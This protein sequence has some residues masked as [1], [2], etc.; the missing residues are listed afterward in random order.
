[1][2]ALPCG[3]VTPGG[4]GMSPA[5]AGTESAIINRTDRNSFMAKIPLTELSG[6]SI[7][8]LVANAWQQS[9]GMDFIGARDTL[10]AA[11]Y[12]PPKTDE[13]DPELLLLQGTL[14]I[15]FS[16][17]E[18]A[19]DVLSKS[20]RF[21]AGNPRA[22]RAR[23][24]LA[25]AY[26]MG[27]EKQEARALLDEITTTEYQCCYLMALA[28]V[29]STPERS[30]RLYE[31]AEPLLATEPVAVQ[32][33]FH[34]SRGMVLRKLANEKDRLRKK[35]PSIIAEL[36]RRSELEYIAT[37]SLAEDVNAH[38][39]V[40]AA[41]NNLAGLYSDTKQT[42][43]A[44]NL[45]D[46]VV[47]HFKRSRRSDCL[48]KSLDQK[49]GILLGQKQLSE[50]IKVARLA[51][52]EL[53]QTDRHGWL[54]EALITLGTA[55]ARKGDTE[56]CAQ[57]ERAT[58]ICDHSGDKE[59]SDRAR[60]T[61]IRELPVSCEQAFVLFS[62]IEDRIQAIDA[63]MY[64][65]EAESIRISLEAASGSKLKAAKGL[66]ITRQA[67]EKKIENNFP[68]FSKPKRKRRRVLFSP[69]N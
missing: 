48:G 12:W 53:E 57:L 41:S 63:L 34:G 59:Q 67:L 68:Q 55:L 23:V 31:Q 51:V 9:D 17:I 2:V 40:I 3:D 8:T 26:L 44:L 38:E 52:G 11:G 32:A 69:R 15:H 7:A 35:D 36:R 28:Y 6:Q 61:I 50:A 49:A 20:V 25:W 45:V 24:M 14:L 56:A 16:E 64:R 65:L 43:E 10:G 21:F 13:S 54:A 42:E 27:G 33:K 60:V 5:N 58:A 47:S 22:A 18:K 4:N 66:G 37:L 29:Q 30:L 46:R 19:K 1:M 39:V 62:L